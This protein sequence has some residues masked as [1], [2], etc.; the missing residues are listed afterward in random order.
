MIPRSSP[1]LSSLTLNRST[2]TP[3]FLPRWVFNG[4]GKLDLA[5][6]SYSVPYADTVTTFLGNGD[7]TFAVSPASQVFNQG[8]TGGDVISGGACD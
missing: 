7:G 1:T 5:V 8:P 6:L 2:L 4:D 3:V